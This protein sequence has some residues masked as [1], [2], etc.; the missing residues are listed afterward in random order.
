M[1]RFLV[2]LW[3]NVQVLGLTFYF[4][5]AQILL[6]VADETASTEITGLPLPHRVSRNKK[7]ESHARQDGYKRTIPTTASENFLEYRQQIWAAHIQH[8]PP[9]LAPYLFCLVTLLTKPGRMTNVAR[10]PTTLGELPVTLDPV[11]W[12]L[13]RVTTITKLLLMATVASAASFLLHRL[14][15]HIPPIL[16]CMALRRF[17]M[18]VLTETRPFAVAPETVLSPVA[19]KLP[20][21]LNCTLRMHLVFVR[22]I[23]VASAT[24]V[25]CPIPVVTHIA[26]VHGRWTSRFSSPAMHNVEVAICAHQIPHLHMLPVRNLQVT[27]RGHL[28]IQ[29]VTL[30]AR[31]I[32]RSMYIFRHMTSTEEL[33]VYLLIGKD[34]V[35]NLADKTGIDVTLYAVDIGV[36]GFLPQLGRLHHE[37]AIVTEAGHRGHGNG[38]IDGGEPQEAN[39]HDKKDKIPHANTHR[40]ATLIVY[41]ENTG[42]PAQHPSGTSHSSSAPQ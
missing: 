31:R 34:L 38:Q 33:S 24:C 7:K 23:T 42:P 35:L 22:G 2:E 25:W 1:S 36:R 26:Y 13:H 18:T 41:P 40:P 39:I 37:M 12:M 8:I 4:H 30:E 19:G 21:V 29:I 5:S 10:F 15:V 16:S 9:L 27:P 14:V 6:T 3:I 11:W 17:L 32:R 20:M 28:A